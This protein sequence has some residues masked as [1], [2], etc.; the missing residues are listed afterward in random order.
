MSNIILV[1]G[2]G[3]A[4]EIFDYLQTDIDSGVK[5]NVR[6]KGV[7][8]GVADCELAREINIS[9]LGKIEEYEFGSNDQVIITFGDQLRRRKFYHLLKEKNVTFYTYI[10]PSS[11]I[12]KKAVLA[13]GVIISPHCIVSANATI[14]SNV[15]L[16]VYCGVGHGAKVGAHSVFSPFSVINGNC[17]LGEATFLGSRV[18][19]YPNVNIGDYTIIDAGVILRNSVGS[20][21]IV[22]Q[23]TEQKEHKNRLIDRSL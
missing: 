4:L 9:Y 5:D 16:N 15:T 3:F 7:L 6:I 14:Q 8:D 13:E 10:H 17:E 19:L 21:L 11:V 18:T 2:G 22:S 12:S 1:G 20:R 23:R